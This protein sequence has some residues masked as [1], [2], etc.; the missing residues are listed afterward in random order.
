LTI[1]GLWPFFQNSIEEKKSFLLQIKEIS[2]SK[3]I[4][5]SEEEISSLQTT[6]AIKNAKKTRKYH[7][8][9]NTMLSVFSIR[10][11]VH[12]G[13]EFKLHIYT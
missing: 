5:S 9:R 11:S 7:K 6:R 1:T 8:I 2:N 3:I 13:V 10:T 4:I 12:P